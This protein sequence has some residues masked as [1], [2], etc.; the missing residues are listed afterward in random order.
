M[1]FDTFSFSPRL[2]QARWT[3]GKLASEDMPGLAQDALTS[4]YDGPAIRR[5]AGLL[6]PVKTD[7]E[8]QLSGFFGE[9]GQPENLS[10]EQAAIVLACFVADAIVE[11][12]ETPYEGARCIWWE[13][14]NSVVP[15]PD[16][17]LSF[18]GEASEYEDCSPYDERGKRWREEIEQ[19]IKRDAHELLVSAG[20]SWR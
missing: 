17:L 2:I 4:G 14:A 5:L 8:P 18:V 1:R 7:V 20:D 12:R 19:Q 6:N 11:G 16:R 3:L 15:V 10:Q 9:L 13:I